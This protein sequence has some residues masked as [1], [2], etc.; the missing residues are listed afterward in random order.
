M[1][2]ILLLMLALVL[3]IGLLACG[4]PTSESKTE[5]QPTSVESVTESVVESTPES[6]VESTPESVAVT[7]T[8]TFVQEGCDNVVVTVNEGEGVSA[9]SIPVPASVKGHTVSWDKTEA[10]L[11]EITTD[12]TVTAVATPNVYVITFVVDYEGVTAPQSQEVTYG[13]EFTLPT[14]ADGYYEFKHWETEDGEVFTASVYEIDDNLTLYAVF[15]SYTY[16]Y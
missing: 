5:S 11:A 15:H 4:N 8:V 2:K 6:T 14:V 12:V 13:T 10:D 3:S 1:K 16:P 9:D 7:Y